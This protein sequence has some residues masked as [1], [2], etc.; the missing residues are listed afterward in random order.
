MSIVWTFQFDFMYAQY[1]Y[2]IMIY[3]IILNLSAAKDEM[4]VLET[5]KWLHWHNWPFNN[6]RYG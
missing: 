6:Q 5:E 4:Y 2:P 1:L 3:F